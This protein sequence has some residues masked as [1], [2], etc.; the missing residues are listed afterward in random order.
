LEDAIAVA[1]KLRVR[2]LWIDSL[3]IIQGNEEDW[4]KECCIM[5]KVYQNSFCN[6]AATASIDSHGGLFFNRQS[7]SPREVLVPET[8]YPEHV[9][10]AG[11][12]TTGDRDPEKFQLL[13]EDLFLREVANGPLLKVC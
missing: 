7:W 9:L 6:I 13:D 3:C 10:G 8:R 11:R 12:L 4:Q 1:R 5:N 2:Y